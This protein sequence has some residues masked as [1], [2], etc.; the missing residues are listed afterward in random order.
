VVNHNGKTVHGD[1]W[2]IVGQNDIHVPYV[3]RIV[4]GQRQVREY[5]GPMFTLMCERALGKQPSP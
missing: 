3:S 5:A 4:R 1:T 2:E